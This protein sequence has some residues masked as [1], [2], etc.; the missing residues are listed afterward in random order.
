MTPECKNK[1]NIYNKNGFYG[2]DGW[3]KMWIDGNSNDR[4]MPIRQGDQV[5][6]TYV[7]DNH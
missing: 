2:Y 7:M 4:T 6:V 5:K 1:K 3:G